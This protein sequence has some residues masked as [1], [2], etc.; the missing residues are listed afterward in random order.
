M[1]F[2]KNHCSFALLCS[3]QT[4]FN[5]GTNRQNPFPLILVKNE[6]VKTT[7]KWPPK[8]AGRMGFG[9]PDPLPYWQTLSWG[10]GYFAWQTKLK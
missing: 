10:L 8:H 5:S 9:P 3:I 4:M 7:P 1:W 6:L 2:C